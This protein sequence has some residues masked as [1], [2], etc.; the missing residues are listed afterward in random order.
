M[1]V[2]TKYD[3]RFDRKAVEQ[4]GFVDIAAANAESTIPAGIALAEERFNGIDDPRSIAGRPS[5]QFEA[6]QAAKVITGYKPP[7]KDDSP[8]E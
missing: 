5:D 8:S 1:R 7:K 4:T 6:A 2:F 3:P